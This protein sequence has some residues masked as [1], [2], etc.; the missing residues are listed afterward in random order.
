M[1]KTRKKGLGLGWILG[2]LIFLC[3]PNITVI[4]LLPDWIGYLLL[5]RGLAKLSD[6]NETVGASSALFRRMIL[7]DAAKLLAIVWIFGMSAASERTA[8]IL[9]WTFVFAVL[10][11]IFLIPAF[12]KLF[13]GLTEIGYFYP[14]TSLLHASSDEKRSRTDRMSRFTVFF[15]VCKATL[16]V[17]PEFADL[18]NLS[19]DEGSG[20][21]NLYRY[22]GLMRAMAFIPALIVGLVWLARSIAYFR[23]LRADSDLMESLNERYR[24]DIEPRV[25]LFAR[26]GLQSVYVLLTL[27][28]VLTLDLRLDGQNCLPDFFAAVLFFAM[29]VTLKNRL[30]RCDRA[31]FGTIAVYFVSSFMASVVEYQFFSHYYYGALIKNESAM[32][33]YGALL[34]CNLCVCAAFG[35]MMWRLARQIR[36]LIREHTGF[37]VGRERA[38]VNEEGMVKAMQGELDRDVLWAFGASALYAFADIACDIFVTRYDFLEMLPWLFG[39]LCIGCWV[40]AMSA[41]GHAVDTKYMLE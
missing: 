21:I 29:A 40:R 19:Y 41:I 7:V 38:S 23:S 16:S 15:V 24:R 18:T 11:M 17:L 12:S 1:T 28:L 35:L 34:I 4:D 20:L 36:A 2:A 10:E 37:V 6:L 32:R 8:S 22:I 3:N 31:L 5:C 13:A 26:R 9:L 14:N 27:A 25:G 39:A 33:N 30:G